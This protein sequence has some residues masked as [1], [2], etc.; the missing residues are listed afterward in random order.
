[1]LKTLRYI[2]IASLLLP[3]ASCKKFLDVNNN[4][5]TASAT[6]AALVFSGAQGNSHRIQVGTN[7]H[8][9]SGTFVGYYAHSTS[10]T[11]G[12]N[13]KQYNF[14]NA[15]FNTFDPVYDNLQ[16]YQ[17]VK[18]NAT[19]EG[20]SFL[21]V[22][23]DIMQVYMYQ[24]VVDLYGNV[25][26]T[27]A[28]KAAAGISPKYDN[29]KNI[30]ED[31]VKRLDASIATLKI[32]TFPTSDIRLQDVMFQGNRDKWIR[33]ANSLKLRILMRQSFMPGRDAYITTNIN[34]TLAEGYNLENVL[35]Q[36]GY[37]PVS[38]KLNPFYSN[39]GFNEVGNIQTNFSYRR[40]NNVILNFLKN[41]QDTLRLNWLAYPT[42]ANSGTGA[43]IRPTA[44]YATPFS[45]F[46]GINLGGTGTTAATSAIG[47]FQIVQGEGNRAGMVMT[48][49]EVLLLQAEASLRYN[50]AFPGGATPKALYEAGVLAHFRLV[51]APGTV[52]GTTAADPFAQR[53]L[54]RALNIPGVVIQGVMATSFN[55][56]YDAN[57][58]FDQ[59]LRAILVQNWV[60]YTHINGLAAWSEYRK[61]SPSPTPSVPYSV[62]T[63]AGTTNP[64]PVRFLYPQSE[65]NANANNVPQ[66]ISTF[67]SRIFWDV[68]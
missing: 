40:M 51:A 7:A 25:P 31:L 1:M 63:T 55:I 34:S 20:V 60:A 16:D 37:Q 33:F 32:T 49:A 59:R 35:I 29:D 36:P 12:G 41:T 52:A 67:T 45:S 50:I 46:V 22:P 8:V 61:S 58:T 39:F 66:N 19:K 57:T 30:Y 6:Q 9:V 56:S 42:T 54:A 13:E 38:G 62:R 65:S 48:L 64:E 28:L 26:Y 24:L 3:A 18:D 2:V 11:G 27:E 17:Y 15:D 68:N 14:T 23:S 47:P 44:P 53:Y 5:N 10:F 21:V 43:F 4:P